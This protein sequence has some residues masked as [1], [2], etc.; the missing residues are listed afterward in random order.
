MSLDQTFNTQGYIIF[1]NLLDKKLLQECRNEIITFIKSSKGLSNAGGISIPDFISLKEFIVTN[2]LRNNCRIHEALK[3]IL[4][5]NYRFCR[6]NDIGIDRLVPWHQDKLNGKY[7]KYETHNIWTFHEGEEQV[8]VKVLIYLQDH[9]TDGGL[10]LVPGSHKSKKILKSPAQHLDV[11]LG[12]VVIFDQR[13]SHRGTLSH[14]VSK[15]ERILVSFGFGR[16]N[17]FT[18]NFERGTIARQL[19]QSGQMKKRWSK[20]IK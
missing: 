3:S 6:H 15:K 16:N 14:P 10:Y 4:G 8:I 1:R 13:I 5:T 20:K 17:I 7:S 9:I 19:D 18:D 2:N 12:D 11:K